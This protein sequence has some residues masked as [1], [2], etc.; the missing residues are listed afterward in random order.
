V[1][2]ARLAAGGGL[3]LLGTVMIFTPG[4][5]ALFLLV[6][7]SIIGAESLTVARLLDRVEVHARRM[8]AAARAWRRG[9]GGDA[10]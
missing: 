7:V 8:F 4:P 10:D 1:P 9:S 6:G 5:G 3:T 2:I